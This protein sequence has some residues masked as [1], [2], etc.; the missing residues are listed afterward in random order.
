MSKTLNS[1]QRRHY[2]VRN[3]IKAAV[4]KSGRPRLSV[5][6]SGKQIYAQIIDDRQGVTLAAAAS[7]EDKKK[8]GSTVEAATVV[9][10][11]VGE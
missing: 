8:S 6:R 3:S 4:A 5:H 9:G 11:L 7:V 10:K 1:K 2:K